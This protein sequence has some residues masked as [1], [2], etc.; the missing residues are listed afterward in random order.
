M[1]KNKKDRFVTADKVN[2]AVQQLHQENKDVNCI[3]IRDILGGGSYTDINIMLSKLSNNQ[4][5][6]SEINLDAMRKTQIY[7]NESVNNLINDNLS[8][9]TGEID[10]YKAEC[11]NFAEELDNKQLLNTELKNQINELEIKLAIVNDKLNN[12]CQMHNDT[13]S[14]L[15]KY[16]DLAFN[17]IFSEQNLSKLINEIVEKVGNNKG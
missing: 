17:N 6:F 10:K 4:F 12:E 16:R 7:I 13:K 3:S 1:E 15:K 5:K 11:G 14:E 2:K 8:T 9:L